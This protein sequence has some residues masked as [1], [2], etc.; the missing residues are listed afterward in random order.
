MKKLL[1]I[2][3][4]AISVQAT[5]QEFAPIGAKWHYDQG[6]FNPDL[7]T[8]QT[9]ESISDTIING[10][11]CRKLM[12]I[13]RMAGVE[14]SWLYMYSLNDSVLFY[15]GNGF[16]LLYDF[17]AITGDTITLGYYTTYDG[18]PLKMVIDSTGTMIINGETRKLQYVSCGDG[19][20]IEFGGIV[21]EGIGN[22]GYMFPSFDPSLDG[23]LRC[24]EDS[25]IGLFIN[26]YH[27]NNGWNFQ[28]CEQVITGI[29]ERGVTSDIMI[30]PNPAGDYIHLNLTGSTPLWETKI[31]IF[32]IFGQIIDEMIFPAGQ[33]EFSCPIT[34]LPVG[35]YS[36]VLTNQQLTKSGKMLI[37]R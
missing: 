18:S 4:T 15:A 30:Y 32:N 10:I 11:P 21:I 19:M 3:L 17:G 25:V 20:V 23:P 35:F 14:I 1:F 29:T 7:T 16:H 26:P 5:S 28:D 34:H 24:Y 36:Y 22:I 31:T 33:Q 13:S 8:Y 2:I 9:I 12:K 27:S 6:T 37:A